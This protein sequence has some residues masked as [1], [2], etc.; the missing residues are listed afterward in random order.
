METLAPSSRRDCRSRAALTPSPEKNPRRDPTTRA[1][2][3]LFGASEGGGVCRMPAGGVAG[4]KKPSSG[5]RCP[6]SAATPLGVLS[7][8][9][10]ESPTRRVSMCAVSLWL[11]T[12]VRGQKAVV[13][14]VYERRHLW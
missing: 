1:Y 11:L 2:G 9:V 8:P 4:R 5:I 13:S 3:R 14:R 6:T 12:V 10:D 7:R